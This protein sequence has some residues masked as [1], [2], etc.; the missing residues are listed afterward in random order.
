MLVLMKKTQTSEKFISVPGGQIFLKRWSSP[1]F[2]EKSPII[3]LHESLGCVETW[4]DFPLQLAETLKRDVIAYDRLGFG[5]SS[6]R[7]E[8][9]SS[10]FVNAEARFIFPEIVNSLNL[11]NFILFGHSV[12]GAM[13]VIIAGLNPDKCE[14]LITESTQS[15]VEDRTR[16]SIESAAEAFKK[17]EFFSKLK[18]Y[19]GDKAQW[20]LDAWFKVW[21]S[22]SFAGWSLK[23]DLKAVVCKTLVMHGDRDEY[24]SLQFPEMI[25]KNVTGPA[26]KEIIENC[27]HV[28]HREKP[29]LILDLVK[30]FIG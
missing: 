18:K 22:N 26:Q 28:P 20:V 30:K 1:E 17:P 6:A 5:K 12:G 8:L 27:G 2:S 15:F 19:H 23:N 21:L 3:L 13:A 14:A 9:P 10:G 11:Q 16:Q 4:R 29:E 7:H 25:F 24:G